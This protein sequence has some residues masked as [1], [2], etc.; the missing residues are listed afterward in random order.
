MDWWTG[1]Q[2]R[3][4]VVG[5]ASECGQCNCRIEL[6]RAAFRCMGT[7]CQVANYIKGFSHNFLYFMT[8]QTC[9]AFLLFGLQ[10][11]MKA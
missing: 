7:V 6:K 1:E 4:G 3:G 5:R 2:V 9:V 8:A 10:E 11:C